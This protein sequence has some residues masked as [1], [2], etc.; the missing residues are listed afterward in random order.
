MNELMNYLLTK[1]VC[2]TARA[3]P[4]LLNTMVNTHI[5]DTLI[6]VT[7]IYPIVTCKQIGFFFIFEKILSFDLLFLTGDTNLRH[8]L[9]SSNFTDRLMTVTVRNKKVP[10]LL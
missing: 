7:N 10:A 8:Q 4:G 1:G 9:V 6:Q 3:T 2:R 5:A